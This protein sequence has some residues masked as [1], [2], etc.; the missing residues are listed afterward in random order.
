MKDDLLLAAEKMAAYMPY[1]NFFVSNVDVAEL[2]NM[3]GI[4]EPYNVKV[5][6]NNESSLYRLI[7]DL[8]NALKHKSVE[9]DMR[10]SKTIF[11][12]PR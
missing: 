7:D 3:T 1:C 9:K 10:T 12:K 5:Y 11:R 6:D 8:T 2:V 4:N